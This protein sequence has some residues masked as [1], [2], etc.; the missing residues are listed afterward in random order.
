MANQGTNTKCFVAQLSAMRVVDLKATTER[1]IYDWSYLISGTTGK[2]CSTYR[3][4]SAKCDRYGPSTF[5]AICTFILN[6]HLGP[7]AFSV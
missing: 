4:M 7:P 2:Y 1:S 3:R 5:T 6:P